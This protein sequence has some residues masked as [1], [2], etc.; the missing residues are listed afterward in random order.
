MEQG[1][2]GNDYEERECPCGCNH[3]GDCIEEICHP[4]GISSVKPDERIG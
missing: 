1:K 2:S 3:A 4:H